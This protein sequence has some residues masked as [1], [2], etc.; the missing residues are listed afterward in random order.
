VAVQGNCGVMNGKGCGGRDEILKRFSDRRETLS[1]MMDGV[2]VCGP[3][4]NARSLTEKMGD[5]GPCACGIG[6]GKGKI[7]VR[8]CVVDQMVIVDACVGVGVSD[9]AYEGA[10]DIFETLRCGE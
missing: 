5:S 2:Y 9:D 8:V 7:Y 6:I 3:S 4:T 10:S 1:D